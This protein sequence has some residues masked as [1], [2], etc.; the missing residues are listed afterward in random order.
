MYSSQVLDND[1]ETDCRRVGAFAR[2]QLCRL[3]ALIV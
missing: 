3:P 1:L 2:I